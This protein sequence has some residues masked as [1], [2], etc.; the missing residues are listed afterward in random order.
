[1]K[2][3]TGSLLD[4]SKVKT[5]VYHLPDGDALAVDVDNATEEHI[6]LC[7]GRICDTSEFDGLLHYFPRGNA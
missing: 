5:I 3:L 2:K 1:M 4:L 6:D 7:H